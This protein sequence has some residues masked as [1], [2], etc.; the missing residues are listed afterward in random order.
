MRRLLLVT[1]V[2]VVAVLAL[3]PLWFSLFP[4][5]RPDLPPAGRRIAV[6]QG[7]TVNALDRGSGPPV[8]MVHGLPGCAY[9]WTPL[10]DALAARGRRA[11]A[12]GRIGYGRS[13]GR[14]NGDFTPAANALELV[15]LLESED[16]R[17][18][19]V[20]GWSYGGPVAIEAAVLSPERVG[21]VVLVGSGG[22]SNDE[23]EPPSVGPVFRLIMGWVGAVPP[24]GQA[25]QRSATDAAFSDGPVPDWWPAQ[26]SA[27]FGQPN[28]RPTYVEEIAGIAQAGEFVV[29]R[30]TQ[31]ILLIHGDDDRLAP[32]AIGE[33]ID[34]H[35]K[36]SELVVVEGGS[37][38]LPITHTD[39][40]ADRIA[41]FADQ[42]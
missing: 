26:L 15:G 16:L 22:P 3:P 28:T 42:S 37:H 27:N 23:D 40:M 7:L 17:D 2:V 30:V 20:V 18:A 41:A 21:R 35:A 6:G 24:V 25:I 39:M 36:R 8:V 38:M 13:D 29:E 19:T 1:L 11:I 14:T 34:R 32:L 5:D 33:W 12:Y 4:I 31:P 10:V 9:D